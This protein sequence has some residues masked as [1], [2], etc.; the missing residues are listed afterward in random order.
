[1]FQMF[2]YWPGE[3]PGTRTRSCTNVTG[4]PLEP[5]PCGLYIPLSYQQR[6]KPWRPK[7]SLQGQL[8]LKDFLTATITGHIPGSERLKGRKQRISSL[9]QLRFPHTLWA[10]PLDKRENSTPTWGDFPN[11]N[12]HLASAPEKFSLREKDPS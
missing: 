9:V 10:T 3:E 8:L 2:L 7:G 6:Q 4:N 1:M 11:F 5:R 12:L